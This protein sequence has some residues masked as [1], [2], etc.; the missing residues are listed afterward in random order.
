MGEKH[1]LAS[2][3]IQMLVREKQIELSKKCKVKI[4][5]ENITN[6]A[7]RE[8]ICKAC[9]IIEAEIENLNEEHKTKYTKD[10]E[11]YE[12]INVDDTKL[13]NYIHKIF[14]EKK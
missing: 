14:Q 3:E 9:E 10:A 7:I 6:I 11:K 5:M 12:Q 4:N 8:G 13:K 2:E 1:L